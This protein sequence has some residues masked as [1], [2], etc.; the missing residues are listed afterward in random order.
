M[1]VVGARQK[2]LMECVLN[3]EEIVSISH[4]EERWIDQEMRAS[5]FKQIELDESEVKKA[6][7]PLEQVKIMT[8]AGEPEPAPTAAPPAHSTHSKNSNLTQKLT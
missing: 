5:F 6:T 2:I 7:G 1:I 3:D 8:T 4:M